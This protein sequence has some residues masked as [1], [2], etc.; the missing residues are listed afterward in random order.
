M[1][2]AMPI[3]NEPNGPT[4]PEAGVMATKPATAPE[5]M[6]MTV[7]LPF[8]I[9]STIIQV[10]AA[11]A[12]AVWVTS[13]AMPA[14]RPA[15][16]AEPALKP[17]QPTHRSAA[18]IMVSTMLWAG[19]VSLRLP[20][21]SAAIRPAVPELTCTTVPP[22]KSSTLTQAASLDELKKPSGPHTQCAIG[23]YTKIAHRPMNHNMA[24]NFIRS[25]NEPAI[26]AAVMIAK[27]SWNIE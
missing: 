12:V 15:L 1:P 10:K 8:I 9:H 21:M 4:N 2:A 20:S 23:E 6:P 22:A 11:V 14:C 18:P 17:N 5:Q 16:T 27:V 3:Q 25:A 13:M 7:G 19:P 26:S 24:E